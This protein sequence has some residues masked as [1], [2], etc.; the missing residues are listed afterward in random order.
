MLAKGLE[1]RVLPLTSL[2]PQWKFDV[3]NYAFV[4]TFDLREVEAMRVSH[5]DA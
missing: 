4:F 5:F 3:S 1:G 2:P